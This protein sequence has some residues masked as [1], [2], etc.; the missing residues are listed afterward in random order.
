MAH[1]SR[2]EGRFQRSPGPTQLFD[3]LSA[4]L[5]PESK[6]SPSAKTLLFRGNQIP[7]DRFCASERQSHQIRAVADDRLPGALQQLYRRSANSLRVTDQY[8][9]RADHNFSSCG[10]HI[11]AVPAFLAWPCGQSP[12]WF[13]RSGPDNRAKQAGNVVGGVGRTCSPP[14]LGE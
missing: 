8:S 6:R 12:A 11:L 13:P 10:P 14:R 3:P 2:E 4:V 9:V 1:R 7:L 5:T